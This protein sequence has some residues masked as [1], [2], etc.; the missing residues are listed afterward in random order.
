MATAEQQ[1]QSR[2]EEFSS[3]VAKFSADIQ[4]FRLSHKKESYVFVGEFVLR[5]SNAKPYPTRC[6]ARRMKILT[7]VLQEPVRGHLFV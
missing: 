2:V 6:H 4:M 3:I 1:Q 7:R 5:R